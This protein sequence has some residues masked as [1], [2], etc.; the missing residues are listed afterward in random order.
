M[1]SLAEVTGE[2]DLFER[3]LALTKAVPEEVVDQ[4]KVEWLSGYVHA[5]KHVLGE[6]FTEQE[7]EVLHG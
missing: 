1:M 7:L 5:L 6:E 4:A 3:I 2:I